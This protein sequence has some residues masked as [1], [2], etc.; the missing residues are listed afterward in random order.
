MLPTSNPP[1][2]ATYPQQKTP[3]GAIDTHIHMLGGQDEF[4]LWENRVENPAA[5]FDMDRFISAYRTQ[6]KTLGITRTVIV[7][8]I[9]YGSD[10]AVTIEAIHR[11]GRDARGIGLLKDGATEAE[12]ETLARAGVKGIRLNYVHGGVLSWEGAKALAPMLKDRDMH[13]QMLIN[14]D[15][16]MVELADD[17]RA[18][19]V[20]VVFDHIGWP[21]LAQGTEEKGFQMLCA[22]LKEG[23]A[24]AKLS[25]LYRLSDAPYTATDPFVQALVAANSERC[26]WGSD[27][28]YI[29]LAN[30]TM[31]DAGQLLDTFMRFVP[32]NLHARIL[33]A[34]PEKLYGFD[35]V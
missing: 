5:G 7:H 2:P 10:N 32:D 24:F 22:L 15:K 18:C 34:N 33:V 30:A 13:I 27:F 25:G 28:P 11:L 19:T 8:S 4:T 31:P 6:S 3:P 29:M 21:D 23:H 26:L 1:V 9:L 12:V 17:I 35:P 20:P 16:H 14:T